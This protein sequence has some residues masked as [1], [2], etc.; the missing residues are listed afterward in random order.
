MAIPIQ[1]ALLHYVWRS[2]RWDMQ[3]LTLSDGRPLEILRFGVPNHDAGPD[4]L[5]GQVLIDGMQWYGQVEMHVRA[6]DWNLHGH[7][8]D[9]RY[10]NVILHVVYDHDVNIYRSDGSLIPTL[11][12]DNRRMA[13]NV[14]DQYAQLIQS[15]RW[16]PCADL[17]TQVDDAFIRFYLDRLVAHRLAEKA[18]LYALWLRE[19][20]GDWETVLYMAIC[21]TLGLKVNADAMEALAQ[22]VPLSVINKNSHD[23]EIVIAILY[24]QAGLL[25]SDSDPQSMKWL[26]SYEFAKHKYQL[27]SIPQ[28]LWKY[29]RMRPAAFPTIRIAQLAAI[30]LHESQL[31]QFLRDA[32][33]S[34][35]IKNRFAVTAHS[36]WDT[37]FVFGPPV[38]D[39][40]P[41]KLGK[42]TIDLL[43]INAIAPMLYL[44]GDQTGDIAYVDKAIDL[45][46]TIEAEKNH[47]TNGF[48]SLGVKA[49]HAADSQA[50]VHLK[51]QYCDS[52]QCLQCSIGDRL[53]RSS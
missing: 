45:L 12:I 22:A 20:Q 52:K 16:I 9:P 18:S 53:L 48:L 44:Y 1:E 30:Y 32:D 23:P 24:G 19:H 13:P 29:A 5:E 28:L 36:Y 49:R 2:K 3:D 10:D 8:N 14:I 26:Q 27:Q 33:T 6:S 4:F 7:Q 46:Y 17:I 25:S 40:K 34:D 37:R 31:M 50:L 51:R 38:H 41:K 47:I 15:E 39:K 35:E 43:L 11:I 21:R 42:A